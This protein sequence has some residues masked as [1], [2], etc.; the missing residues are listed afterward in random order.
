MTREAVLALFDGWR[1]LGSRSPLDRRAR[2][3]RLPPRR[4][5]GDTGAAADTPPRPLPMNGGAAAPFE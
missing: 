4:P 1:Y 2:G 5:H 3:R